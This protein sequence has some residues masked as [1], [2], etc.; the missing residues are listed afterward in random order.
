[1]QEPPS[2]FA[3]RFFNS[4]YE[5]PESDKQFSCYLNFAVGSDLGRKKGKIF[6]DI[7]RTIFLGKEGFSAAAFDAGVA[8]HQ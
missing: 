6:F 1:M 8:S 5:D 4:T 3:I 2:R 7:A